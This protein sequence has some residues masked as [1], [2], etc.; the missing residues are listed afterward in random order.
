MRYIQQI[1]DRTMVYDYINADMIYHMSNDK[2]APIDIYVEDK[3]AE[4]IVRNVASELGI[5]GNVNVVK[6]GAIT[7]AFVLAAS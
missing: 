7:N 5:I 3:L 2:V 6:Y 4:S 1:D